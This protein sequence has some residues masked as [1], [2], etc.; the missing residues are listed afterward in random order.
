MGKASRE[1][2]ARRA[3]AERLAQRPVGTARYNA[4]PSARTE[5]TIPERRAPLDDIAA[6]AS[7][8]DQSRSALQAAVDHARSL[9][10][11]WTLIGDELGISRQAARQRF[12][13]KGS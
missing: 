1:K 8:F 12:G 11:S 4:R 13:G 5:L 7:A 3:E 10:Y 6:A 9:D 2:A